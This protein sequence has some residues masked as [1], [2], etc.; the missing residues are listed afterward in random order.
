MSKP[1]KNRCDWCGGD[2]VSIEKKSVYWELPEGT[3]AIE[4]TGTP[5]VCCTSCSMEY[6][7]ETMV[8]E[9]EDQLFLIDRTKLASVLTFEDLMSMPRLLKRNY[10]DFS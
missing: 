2:S 3:R 9:I 4:I 1:E 5:T 10:F 8:K 6:Q 7:K